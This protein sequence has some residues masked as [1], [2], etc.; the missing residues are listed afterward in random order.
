[1]QFHT[2]R[3]K[4][5]FILEVS[6]IILLLWEIFFPISFSKKLDYF[7]THNF[8]SEQSQIEKTLSLNINI[9]NEEINSSKETR[10]RIFDSNLHSNKTLLI[11]P[12]K[13]NN[14]FDSTKLNIDSII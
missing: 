11:K 2:V 1:M 3:T 13:K 10:M 7:E 6:T 4:R 14:K 12:V 8:Y 5:F 9:L